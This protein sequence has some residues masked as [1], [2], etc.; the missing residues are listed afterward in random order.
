MKNNKLTVCILTAGKGS[1]VGKIS[2]YLNKSLLPI[3]KKAAISWIIEKFPKDTEFY[4]SYRFSK[5][6]RR[7]FFKFIVKI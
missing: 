2:E 1:R 7:V 3:N 5:P 4:N 6:S